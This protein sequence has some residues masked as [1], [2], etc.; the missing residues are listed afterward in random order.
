MTDAMRLTCEKAIHEVRIAIT[1]INN[2]LSILNFEIKHNRPFE[3]MDQTVTEFAQLQ[4]AQE[5]LLHA[6]VVI[7]RALRKKS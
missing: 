6:N 1:E 5:N 4:I 3:D 2:C 7:K